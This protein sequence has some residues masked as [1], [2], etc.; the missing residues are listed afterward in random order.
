M[1]SIGN[2]KPMNDQP[3]IW[4]NGELLPAGEMRVSPFDLGLTVGLGVFETMAAY[5]GKVFAYEQHHQRLVASA[6]VMDITAPA[7][8]LI[9]NAMLSVLKANDLLAGRARVRVSVSDGVNALTGGDTAGNVI[10]TAVPMPEPMKLARLIKSPYVLDEASVLSGV[11]SASYAGNVIAYRD[12]ARAEADEALMFNKK[13]NLCECTMSNV[14]LVKDG[15]VFTPPLSS[16]CLAGVTRSIV[17][18]LCG[19][20]QLEVSECDLS[21]EDVSQADEIFLTSSAREVQSAVMLGSDS[22]SFPV[23]EKLAVAY[24][25]LVKNATEDGGVPKNS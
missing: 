24:R 13:G 8:E 7:R 5:D 12:A 4:I 25:S 21:E 1:R 22:D 19:K 20:L 15:A 11:K 2:Y 16:G 9:E 23:A 14:F 6:N 17:L 10:V 18:Q 3:I